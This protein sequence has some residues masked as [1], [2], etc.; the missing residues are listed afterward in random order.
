M[1]ASI[2][3]TTYT[4]FIR[5]ILEY[6]FQILQTASAT[7][8]KKLERIQLGAAQIIAG[9]SKKDQHPVLLKQLALET[10][11]NTP[12]GAVR[13]F[14][15][16]SKNDNGNTGSGVIIKTSDA[17]TKIKKQNP[18]F[19]S[20]FRSELIAIDE[21]LDHMISNNSSCDIWIFTDSRSSVQF[22]SNWRNIGDK[23]G[24]DIVNKLRIYSSHNDIH[25]QWIPS[26]VDL[27]FNDLADDLAKE[28]SAEPLDNR[29]LLTY[30]EIFS[31]VRADNN[32]ILRIPP[33]HDWYQ[34]KHLGAAL[35][36]K[37]DRKLQTTITR[38]ISGHTHTLSYVQ[39]QKV[40]PACLECNTHQFTPDHLLSCME[41]EKRN[42]FESPALVRDFLW[43]SGLL[44][45]V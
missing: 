11:H 26:H 15:D 24:T 8:L 41:L 23:T 2:L 29:G 12:L 44:D 22:L 13:I 37:G 28:G 30:R 43:A 16:G 7:N 31:K 40:F 14:T 5:P 17:I 36:L 10:I 1:D 42:L 33:I 6:G 25:L 34:Q 4:S 3:R 21:A 38:F 45:L 32:R 20:V 19:C 27:F 18:N 39:G 9:S 35:E